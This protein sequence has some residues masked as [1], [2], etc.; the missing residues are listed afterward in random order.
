M[1]RVLPMMSLVPMIY[2]YLLYHHNDKLY[3]CDSFLYCILNDYAPEV[4]SS[5]A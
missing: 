3:C 4:C 1:I 2:S 5:G